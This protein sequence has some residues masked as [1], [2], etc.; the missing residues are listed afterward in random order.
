MDAAV[1]T[2]AHEVQPVSASLLHEIEQHGVLKE[3]AGGDHQIDA[4]DVH[5][6]DAA[7]ADIEVPHLAITHLAFGQSHRWTGGVD[8]GVRIFAQEGIVGW[9]SRG[10]DCVSLGGWGESP[11]IQNCQDKRLFAAQH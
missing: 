1:A 3:L 10:G 2:Q 9:L 5:V 7:R 6:N 4:R 8:Q 11:S